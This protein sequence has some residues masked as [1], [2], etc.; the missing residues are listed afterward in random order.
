MNFKDFIYYNE[1]N[2]PHI[3]KKGHILNIEYNKNPIRIKISDGT[4][5]FLH[6]D[7]YKRLNKEP[8]KGDN[9]SIEFQ[10]NPEDIS[11]NPSKINKIFIH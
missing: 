10:R 6:I 3:T 9:I 5:L 7:D 11:E 2:V 1:F 4:Q 8:K